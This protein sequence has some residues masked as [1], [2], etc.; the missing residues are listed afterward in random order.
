[1]SLADALQ[2]AY[3][4]TVRDGLLLERAERLAASYPASAHE[5]M[6]ELF[7]I[8][9]RR[10]SAAADLSDNQPVVA[11]ILY[12][13]AAIA[14]IAAISVSRGEQELETGDAA[15]AFERLDQ[16]NPPIEGAPRD[17][18]EARR[19]LT[20]R[21]PFV[22]DRLGDEVRAKLAMVA[23]VA[24]WLQ[25]AI[26]PRGVRHIRRLRIVRLAF[27]AACALG[28]IAWGIAILVSPKNIALHKPVAQSSVLPTSTAPEGGLTDGST[29]GYGVHTNLEANSWV[30]VDLQDVYQLKK[31]KI[32]NRRDGWFDEG[33]PMTLELSEN[34]TDFTPV[35]RKVAPF[36][37][38]TPWV[39]V[40][41]GKKAR[42]IQV[43][44][45]PGKYVALA[46]LEAYG[47][48]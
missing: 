20:S 23:A 3:Q 38:S 4:S 29:S 8:G 34:G 35:D 39:Y 33:L 30:R 48:K 12:R 26:E 11:P 1:M 9:M 24:T 47:S 21:D 41:N 15:R 14:F 22:F 40:A 13:E 36:E 45:T 19:L 25:E 2:S 44:G 28:L 31:I 43:R 17:Y 46:E 18:D 6:R 16:L 7:E 42:Y 27:L 37:S 10:M 5:R 32:Y